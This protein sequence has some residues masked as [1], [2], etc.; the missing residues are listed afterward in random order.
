MVASPSTRHDPQS[1]D[2]LWLQQRIRGGNLIRRGAGGV[3]VRQH[4]VALGLAPANDP[5]AAAHCLAGSNQRRRRMSH[6]LAA[7]KMKVFPAPC[8]RR[9]GHASRRLDL[10]ILFQ[11]GLFHGNFGA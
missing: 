8:P 1:P 2:P 11:L 9:R 7:S 3:R 5:C 6:G 4:G 10:E